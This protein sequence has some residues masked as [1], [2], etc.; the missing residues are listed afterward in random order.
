M[1]TFYLLT[2]TLLMAMAVVNVYD[3][4]GI[5]VGG[6]T[7]IG[8]MVTE[9]T[10]IPMWAVNAGLNI[11]VFFAAYRILDKKTM[12]YT[13]IGTVALTFFLAVMPTIDI[14]TGDMLVD[15]LV[16]GV[17]MGTGL[18]LIFSKGASSGGTDLLATILNAKRPHMSIPQFLGLV[19]GIIVLAGMYVFGWKNGVYALIS[20]YIMTRMSDY[21]MEGSKKAKILYIISDCYKEIGEFINLKMERGA[22]LIDVQGVYTGESRKMLITVASSRQMVKI[23]KKIYNTDPFAICFVADVGEA[24]GEGFTKFRG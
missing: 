20:L 5:V 23:M 13:L 24:F 3:R 18:G 15:A 21:I 8:I 4:I 9:Y 10:P 17:I 2:G 12:K 11:P 16:G 1:K 7:G 19:D 22:S 6:V 14:L